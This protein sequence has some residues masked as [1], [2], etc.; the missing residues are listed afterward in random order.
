[1][2]APS[3]AMAA[4][5]LE[6]DRKTHTIRFVRVFDAPQTLVFEAW[7]KP[8]QVACWWDAAGGPLASCEIDL[9]TGGAFKFVTNGRPDMPFAGVYREIAPPE[10][11]VFE[12]I[13]AMGRV[14]LQDVDGQTRMTVEIECRSAEQL[15]EYLKMGVDVGTSQTLENLCAYMR[16][17]SGGA[18]AGSDK[19]I[20][21]FEGARR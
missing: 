14:L 11:L 15:D 3:H 16:R 17:R 9:R 20:A 10:R 7:T 1:M 19:P 13:G 21:S 18:S 12:A 6:I 2:P 4:A 8:E 5:N